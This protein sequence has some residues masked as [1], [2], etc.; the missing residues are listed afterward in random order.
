MF[1]G[2][3][4]LQGAFSVFSG[5]LEE[6][7]DLTEQP[8]GQRRRAVVNVVSVRVADALVLSRRCRCDGFQ[9]AHVKAHVDDVLVGGQQTANYHSTDH[10]A[11]ST[12]TRAILTVG[13]KAKCPTA[14]KVS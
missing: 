5:T 13:T 9:S 1:L 2:F 8:P 3:E 11:N 14:I 6:T 10:R 4:Q 12:K 7:I